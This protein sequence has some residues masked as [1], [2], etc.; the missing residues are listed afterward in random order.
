MQPTGAHTLCVSNNSDETNGAFTSGQQMVQHPLGVGGAPH[1]E[2]Q[3]SER[4]IGFKGM[5]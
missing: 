4:W 5:S 1:G 3:K 2:G